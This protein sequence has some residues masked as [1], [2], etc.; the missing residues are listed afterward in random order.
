[1]AGDFFLHVFRLHGLLGFFT[2]WWPLGHGAANLTAEPRRAGVE[3]AFLFITTPR[4]SLLLDSWLQAHRKPA[5]IRQ[6]VN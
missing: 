4:K 2:A 6:Q 5:D 1:M 3:T